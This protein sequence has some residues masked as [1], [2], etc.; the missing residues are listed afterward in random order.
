M[1]NFRYP[2]PTILF[3]SGYFFRLKYNI[4][5]IRARIYIFMQI[6]RYDSFKSIVK[7][8]FHIK[9]FDFSIQPF[10]IFPFRS[11]RDGNFY[12]ARPIVCLKQSSKFTMLLLRV[13]LTTMASRRFNVIRGVLA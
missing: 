10:T 1:Y 9:L 13:L 5:F 6:V 12:A 2:H 7:Y 3:S 8:G 11:S 4:Y